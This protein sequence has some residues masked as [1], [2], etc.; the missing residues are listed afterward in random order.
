MFDTQTL[1]DE[2][3]KTQKLINTLKEKKE[4]LVEQLVADDT[5]E[6]LNDDTANIKKYKK[7]TTVLKEWVEKDEM[8]IR[9]PEAVKTSL[10]MKSLASIE[11]A[12]E[13]LELKE[14]DVLSVQVKS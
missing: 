5:F 9:F 4:S 1:I 14:S 6:W 11:W 8:M 2:L 13:Y 12:H 7:R 10:D 3:I